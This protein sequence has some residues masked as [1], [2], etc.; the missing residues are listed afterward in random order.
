MAS[1]SRIQPALLGKHNRSLVNL[2]DANSLMKRGQGD[3]LVMFS[4]GVTRL[5]FAYGVQVYRGT[6]NSD[7]LRREVIARAEQAV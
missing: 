4:C 6:P 1:P 2:I 7:M 5:G 3:G